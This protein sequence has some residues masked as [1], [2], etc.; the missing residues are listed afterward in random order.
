MHLY[1]LKEAKESYSPAH[2]SWLANADKCAWQICFSVTHSH[3]HWGGWSRISRWK[4]DWGGGRQRWWKVSHCEIIKTA[5]TLMKKLCWNEKTWSYKGE[6]VYRGAPMKWL[7]IM[8]LIK[9]FVH[10]SRKSSAPTGWR[11]VLHTQNYMYPRP[12]SP[13]PGSWAMWSS[14]SGR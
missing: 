14:E 7:Y 11:N 1:Q 2:F 6:F 12:P 9:H 5:N 8:D 4:A 13:S 3:T 10:W